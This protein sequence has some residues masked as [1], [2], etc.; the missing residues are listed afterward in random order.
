MEKRRSLLLQ[1][2]RQVFLERRGILKMGQVWL[3]LSLILFS[4]TRLA[5]GPH[6]E[7]HASLF[8]LYAV[9]SKGLATILINDLTDREIDRRAGKERWI[10]SL[11]SPAGIMIP[12]LL[13]ASGFPALLLAGGGLFVLASFTATVALGIL[14]SL[15]PVR[16]KERGFWGPLAYT[17]SAAI[18][19]ALVPWALFH[20]AFWLLPLLFIVVTGE[21]FVQMLFHQVL[22]FDSDREE[23]VGS[24]AVRAGREKA[25]R[26]LRLILIFALAADA[27]LLVCALFLVAKKQL[28][29]LWLLGPACL[30]AVCAAG[31]YA[32]VISKK[33]GASTALT[34][35]LPWPYLGI[36]Y[37]IF[38]LLPPLLFLILSLRRQEMWTL[39]ALSSLW[40]LGISFNIFRYDPEE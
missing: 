18:L 6:A 1:A 32:K 17:L 19:H 3:P 4:G 21:K 39:T 13:L 35:R 25:G 33:A 29:F 23:K 27:V 2:L 34:E 5:P 10:T 28:T 36:S 12:V 15:K 37:V 16:F 11:P 40:L 24:F 20:P 7:L 26:T 8:F 31:L 22:D 9:V 38:Y 14:Y 30:L